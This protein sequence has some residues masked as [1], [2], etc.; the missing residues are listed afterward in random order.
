MYVPMGKRNMNKT[1]LQEILTTVYKEQMIEFLKTHPEQFGE[2]LEMAVGDEQPYCW[3]SA[4]LLWSCM[5]GND[6]RIQAYIDKFLEVMPNK[7]DG[8]QREL[9]KILSMM[10]LDE[11]QEGRLFDICMNLWESINKR[12]SVRSNALMF[13]LKTAKKYPELS[14]EINFITQE[15]YLE[16]LSPGIKHSIIRM[17]KNIDGS[18]DSQGR[19]NVSV[20]DWRHHKEI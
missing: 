11:N 10:E 14:G 13:I 18:V 1:R 2:A 3:R 16:T 9:L 6:K 17:V 20:D 7:K 8:H 4:W 15:Q 5:E 12:P 19:T